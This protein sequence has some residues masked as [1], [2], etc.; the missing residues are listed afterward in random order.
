VPDLLAGAELSLTCIC[1]VACCRWGRVPDQW[2]L[3]PFW[4]GV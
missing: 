3:H 1:A 2:A 4:S